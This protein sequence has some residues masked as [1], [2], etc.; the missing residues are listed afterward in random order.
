M[1]QMFAEIPVEESPFEEKI[2]LLAAIWSERR[3]G[4]L[5]VNFPRSGH[6]CVARFSQGGLFDRGEF[7]SLNAALGA[8]HIAFVAGEFDAPSDWG[9]VGRLLFQRTRSHLQRHPTDYPGVT[10][11]CLTRRPVLEALPIESPVDLLVQA[12][13]VT[14]RSAQ[15]ALQVLS[16][17]GL[18]EPVPTRAP[19]P[20]L[21]NAF[22]V[23]GRLM[24]S[25][26][27]EASLLR[28]AWSLLSADQCDEADRMLSRAALTRLDQPMV[29]GTLAIACWRNPRRSPEARR[30]RALHWIRLARQ[31]DGGDRRLRRVQAHLEAEIN[32]SQRSA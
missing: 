22:R 1:Q 8:G 20:S 25:D 6:R 4:T 15:E 2:R 24:V 16:L 3:T 19:L 14:D 21:G 12:P 30:E 7:M 18:I 11:R 10:Y 17:M 28:Q 26:V 13:S 5:Y 9:A 27:D 23:E 32:A 29:L 31:L